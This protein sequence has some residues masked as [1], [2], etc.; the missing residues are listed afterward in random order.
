MSLNSV[1]SAIRRAEHRFGRVEGAVELVAVSKVQP[2]DRLEAALQAGQRRFGEN[3]VQEALSKWPE[4]QEKYQNVILHLVGPLQSN[5]VKQAVEFFD[6]IETV[7]RE[8]LARKL[9]EEI[10]ATGK[11]LQLY[12]QVN[13]GEEAQKAGVSPKEVD[14]FVQLCV[15]ELSLPIVGLMCIPPAD[16]PPSPHFAL[17]KQLSERNDLT[18]LSMGMSRDFELAISLGATSVRVGSAVFGER[19]SQ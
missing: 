11:R 18:K 8:K 16:E 15:K 6:V 5:K 13:T 14:A 19:V 3:R 9:A 2:L 12:I 7:D 1:L 4:L 17:L 10:S